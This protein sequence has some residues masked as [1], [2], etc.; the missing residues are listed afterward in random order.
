MNIRNQHQL[1]NLTVLSFCGFLFLGISTQNA[2][3]RQAEQTPKADSAPTSTKTDKSKETPSEKPLTK[4]P[5]PRKPVVEDKTQPKTDRELAQERMA[6][7]AAK[8]KGEYTFD[9]IKFDIEKGG[10]FQPEMITPELKKL[11]KKV[12]TLRGFMLPASVFQ[13]KGIKKFVLVRDDRECCF[14]PGAALYDCVMVEMAPGKAADFSI[15]MVAVKGKF[16][17]DTESFKEPG[18]GYEAVYKITAEEAK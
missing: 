13:Q 9:D 4:R 12:I 16:E 3:A 6:R 10:E 11:D 8:R 5:D 7:E 2:L 18:G 14:G 17:I 1:A 15:R